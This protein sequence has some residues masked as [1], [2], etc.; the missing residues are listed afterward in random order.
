M[1]IKR[2]IEKYRLTIAYIMKLRLKNIETREMVKRMNFQI[3]LA[4]SSVFLT[5]VY[6]LR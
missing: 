4:F 2:L 6:H 5:H 1:M 3:Q